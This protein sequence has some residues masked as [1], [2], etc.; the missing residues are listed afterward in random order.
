MRSLAHRVP[1]I[2]MRVGFCIYNEAR[3]CGWRSPVALDVSRFEALWSDLRV[4]VRTLK[5]SPAFLAVV[6]LSLT[7]GIVANTTISRIIDSL[8]F[9]PLLYKHAEQMTDI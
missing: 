1:V 4:P 2:E 6:V 8:L 5:K 3:A 9:R 7:L